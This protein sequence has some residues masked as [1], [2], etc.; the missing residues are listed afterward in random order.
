[1]GSMPTRT[2]SSR[3]DPPSREKAA[4]AFL[5]DLPRAINPV[6][7]GGYAMA[8]YGPPRY[9]VDV[10]LVVPGRAEEAATSW[11]KEYGLTSRKTLRI[12]QRGEEWSKY[13][14]SGGAV[15]GDVYVGGMQARES[16]A[17]IS[18]NWIARRPETTRLALTTG[19]TRLPIAVARP[20][21]L[22]V[23]KLLAAR[24]QDITDL[25]GI[26]TRTMDRLEVRTELTNLFSGPVR[27]QLRKLASRVNADKEYQ[28]ALS[29]RG[30]G[31][32]SNP[33]NLARWREF[34]SLVASC[35][36]PL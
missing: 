2:A 29:R 31:S 13:R 6:I 14:I 4:I 30:L 17:R 25:F 36:P 15:S 3:L 23:L 10:D 28:D 34:Q 9:S 33:R 19:S 12:R 18:Y 16:Q 11:F 20:E 5:D 22:W 35:I 21:A 27:A 1:M 32:P 26:S 24:P 8:A 7:V